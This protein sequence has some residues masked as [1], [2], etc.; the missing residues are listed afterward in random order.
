MSAFNPFNRRTGQ[1][2]LIDMHRSAIASP[3]HTDYYHVVVVV[4][5]AVVVAAA[6]LQ[7]LA[8]PRRNRAGPWLKLSASLS[9]GKKPQWNSTGVQIPSVNT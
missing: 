7:H 6:A 3:L 9:N 2:V 1:R 5:V 8:I 4:I